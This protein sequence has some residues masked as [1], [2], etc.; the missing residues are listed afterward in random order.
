M[1][2]CLGFQLYEMVNAAALRVRIIDSQRDIYYIFPRNMFIALGFL[3]FQKGYYMPTVRVPEDRVK[4]R[5]RGCLPSE[6]G[7][8][9]LGTVPLNREFPPQHNSPLRRTDKCLMGDH[10]NSTTLSSYRRGNSE[11]C[12]VVQLFMDFSSRCSG[13]FVNAL[14]DLP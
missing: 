12:R 4:G 3:P 11:T 7:P 14:S 9:R 8:T 13:C 2:I 6:I 1:I 5:A 10:G